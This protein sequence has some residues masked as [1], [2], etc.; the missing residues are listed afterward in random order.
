MLPQTLLAF[1]LCVSAV[2]VVLPFGMWQ[3]HHQIAS[4]EAGVL[5]TIDRVQQSQQKALH[6]ILDVQKRVGKARQE[7]EDM[8][9]DA[10]RDDAELSGAG[11]GKKHKKKKHPTNFGKKLDALEAAFGAKV[12]ELDEGDVKQFKEMKDNVNALRNRFLVKWHSDD[13]VKTSD[14]YPT[15]RDALDKFNQIGEFA[16]KMLMVSGKRWIVLREYGGAQWLD[17]MTN[18]GELQD[19][20]GK[21]TKAPKKE[22]EPADDSANE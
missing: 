1:L 14:R 9:A 21:P 5:A 18:D 8:V 4:G 20:D 6:N 3:S 16:K 17:I 22:D 13:G 12:A 11:G 19:G 10:A 2:A 15:E 7:L